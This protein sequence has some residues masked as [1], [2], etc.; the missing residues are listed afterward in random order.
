[1]PL[2]LLGRMR[3]SAV[4]SAM[5]AMMNAIQWRSRHDGCGADELAA[6]IDRCAPLDRGE[7]YATPDAPDI[8]EHGGEWSWDSPLPS[9]HP[10]NDRVRVRLHVG[11]RGWSAPTALILHALMSAS[12]IGYRRL[13]DWFGERGWNAAFAHLPF[14]YSRVPPRTLNGQLAVSSNLIRNAETIRQGVVELRQL[15]RALRARGCTEFGLVGTSFGGWIGGILASLEADFRFVSLI[16]PIADTDHAIWVNP[17]AAMIRRQLLA[18]GIAR[19]VSDRHAHLS[20]P[21]EG[22]PLCGA[23]RTVIVAGEHDAVSPPSVLSELA[24]RWEGSE[25]LVVPQGHFGYAALREA[26]RSIERRIQ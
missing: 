17:G 25:F 15:M 10:R 13:A 23:D 7:F 24:R 2:A 8:T 18:R 21:L 16:Q 11:D 19:G 26:M 4:D 14:H 22:R 9:G 5:C 6:Y 20:A 12:D 1:M 3:S